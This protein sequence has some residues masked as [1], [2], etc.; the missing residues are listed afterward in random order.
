MVIRVTC[1]YYSLSL[2]FQRQR[3]LLAE[4][5]TRADHLTSVS[6]IHV[7]PQSENR[8]EVFPFFLFFFIKTNNKNR[9]KKKKKDFTKAS[10]S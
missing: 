1:G 7:P 9:K 8:F 10:V 3:H 2:C 5:A 4:F 6:K